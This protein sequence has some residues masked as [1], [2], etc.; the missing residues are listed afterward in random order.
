MS[1][2]T[3]WTAGLT[4]WAGCA[5]SFFAGALARGADEETV[6]ALREAAGGR[7]LLRTSRTTGQGIFLSAARGHEIPVAGDSAQERALAFVDRYGKA[8]GLASRADLRL[9]R[10]ERDELGVQHVRYQQTYRGLPITGAEIIVHLRENGVSAVS[11]KA[12]AEANEIS[13]TPTLTADAAAET[14]RTLVTKLYDA[15]DAELSAPR[16][17]IF[18]HRLLGG[19]AR[20]PARL[21]WFVE[22]TGVGV[23]EFIW[24]DAQRGSMLLNFSQLTDARRRQV[25]TAKHNYVLPGT[26]LRSEGGAPVPESSPY[27]EDANAAYDYAG[28]TYD[29]FWTQHGRDS[30]DGK[31]G[32]LRSTVHFWDFGTCPNAFWDGWET[33]YCEGMP[34]ADEVNAHEFTHGVTDTTANLFYWMQSGALN[35]SFSDIFGETI[36]QTNGA[37]NDDASVRWQVGEDLQIDVDGDGVPG[38]FRDMMD[39]NAFSNPAWTGDS[40]YY[41]QEPSGGVRDRGGVHTN[42]GVPNHLYALITDGG[43][44]NGETITGLGLDKAGKIAYRTLTRYLGSGSD[45][46]DAYHAFRQACDDLV[47]TPTGT[48]RFEAADCAEVQK[49]LDAVEM[50]HAVCGEVAE[51]AACPD[52]QGPGATLLA[53][54]FEQPNAGKWSTGATEGTNTWLAPYPYSSYYVGTPRIYSWIYPHTGAYSL[55]GLDAGDTSDSLVSMARDVSL[56]ADARLSMQHY[57]NFEDGYDGGVL[58]YSANGGPWTD[59]LGLHLG[60]NN[61]AADAVKGG[62]ALAGRRAF[63]GFAREWGASLYDLA[64]L[65]GQNVR[66]RFRIATDNSIGYESYDGWL[67]DDVRIYTCSPGGQVQ[68][69]S[70]EVAVGE[71]GGSLTLTVTRTGGSAEGVTVA[72]RTVDG[73][74]SAG[75]DYVATTGTVQFGAGETTKTFTVPIINDTLDDDGGT[76]DVV[77]EVVNG[78]GAELG[79]PSTATVTIGDDDAAGSMQFATG[80]VSVGEAGRVAT[81]AVVRAGGSASGATVN[82]ATVAGGTATDSGDDADYTPVSGTLTF[83]A[84]QTTQTFTV[85]IVNDCWADGPETVHLE[86]SAPSGDGTL[87]ARATAI[88]TIVD[89]DRAGVLQL[90]AA[91]VSVSEGAGSATIAVVRTGGAACRVTVGYATSDGTASAGSD[92]TS[93]AGALTFDAGQTSRTFS[94]PINDDATGEN[95]ET[96]RLAIAGPTGGATLGVR[97][98]AVLNIVE[99]ERVFQFGAAGYA[100]TEG[101]IATITVKRSGLLTGQATVQYSTGDGS[102]TTADSDYTASSGTLAF[103]SSVVAKTFTVKTGADTKDE[104]NETVVLHLSAPGSGALGPL[105]TAV[106]TITDNDTAGSARFSSAK[107]T[108]AE[109]ATSA[110]ITVLRRGGVA[111]PVEVDYTASAGTATDGA[112]FSATTG[113]LTFLA[114]QM[115]KTF[116]VTLLPDTLGEGAETVNLSLGELTGGLTL[117]SPGTSVLTIT[118]D[119]SAVELTAGQLTVVEGAR[120]LVQVRRTGRLAG[121]V[122]VAYHMS[123]GTAVAPGDYTAIP[124]GTLTFNPGVAQATIAVPTANDTDDEDTETVNVTLDGVTNELGASAVLGHQTTGVLSITDNDSGGAFKLGAEKHTVS[125]AAGQV[126]ITVARTGGVAGNVTVE[127]LVGDA[128]A[129]APGDYTAP[130]PNPVVLSFS[131]GQITKTFT[132]PI[133]NDTDPEG[134]ETFTLTLQNP[135]GGATLGSPSVGDVTITD[136]DAPVFHLSAPEHTVAVALGR[137]E[138]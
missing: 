87:G 3:R 59:A 44:F 16:L 62:G 103:A 119:D 15:A 102:A 49:A 35:E 69:P 57:Y 10:E 55:W 70:A 78:P 74:A 80:A 50:D 34:V 135:T 64:S 100:V 93:T 33:V 132:I 54:D 28:D 42:S 4:V 13:T 125:E 66:F 97:S 122:I 41:C 86:L 137:G 25:Y 12:L 71:A 115:S 105:D 2:R 90:G 120:G 61:Y 56:P 65:A 112:D 107:Y 98:T 83:G 32:V 136:N 121:R 48:G 24:I 1:R 27:A 101:G 85:P 99:N 19:P 81:I 36:D 26:L 118:D 43:T 124:A 95:D 110:T 129:T 14:A 138:R 20:R 117:G 114:G 94:V 58:E 133:I 40:Y 18:A 30:W 51:P 76:F 96:V 109:S 67:V 126:T 29:Y 92:Y 73:T 91:A 22:A 45:F 6:R 82:F 23:R 104:S 72:Y 68:F 113:T 17:E 9:M 8:F 130:S 37:G 75:Q 5:A 11:A 79:T 63:T 134:A 39:P 47:G 7:A 89:D 21:A 84:G 46:V 77:L 38:A 127:C 108:V 106:L 31:G 131:A 116:T 111:G 53:G 88:L 123:D 128:S 60:G 52:G